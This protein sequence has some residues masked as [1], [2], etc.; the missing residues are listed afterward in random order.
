MVQRILIEGGASPKFRISKPGKDV[1]SSTSFDDF[2]IREDAKSCWPRQVV[3]LAFTGSGSQNISL[4]PAPSRAPLV[5]MK[6]SD[7]TVCGFGNY[8]A[9]LNRQRTT[10]TVVSN[11]GV[12]RTI[13][14]YIFGNEIEDSL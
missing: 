6:S 7:N 2:V 5:L 10:L 12:A 1:S 13:T 3:N 4:S 14:V 11:R 8:W 9:R